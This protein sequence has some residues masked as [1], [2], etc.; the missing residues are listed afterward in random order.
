MKANRE[1]MVPLN[2]H[3][4]RTIRDCPYLRVADAGLLFAGRKLGSSLSDMSVTKVRRDTGLGYTPHGFRSSFRD[5]TS[6][7]TKCLDRV[8][9][10]ALAHA[11]NGRTE[12]AYRR[13]VLLDSA[14]DSWEDGA[15]IEPAA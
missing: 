12:A 6:E 7:T 8:V 1:P 10:A 13:G 14:G 15:A 5:W 2:N 3:A 4:C 11:V 9:E